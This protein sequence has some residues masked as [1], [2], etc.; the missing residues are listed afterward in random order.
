MP[1][2]GWQ[3]FML[4]SQGD[5]SAEVQAFCQRHEAPMVE[6]LRY[7]ASDPETMFAPGSGTAV[8]RCGANRSVAGGGVFVSGSVLEAPLV[9]S[10]PI[11]LGDADDVPDDGWSAKAL[12]ESGL[13]KTVVAHAIC[14]RA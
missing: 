11:D 5:G 13:G 7:V 3:G 9:R 4:D 10:A 12:N 8:A 2:D 14:G 1:D 6:A